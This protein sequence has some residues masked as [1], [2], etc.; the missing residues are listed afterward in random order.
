M[1]FRFDSRVPT[2]LFDGWRWGFDDLDALWSERPRAQSPA[3][4]GHRLREEHESFVLELDVPGFAAADFQIQA[5]AKT[6]RV[7]AS[8]TVEAPKGSDISALRHRLER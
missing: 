5:D 8:R 1:F 3:T 2:S 6:V 4:D 7:E